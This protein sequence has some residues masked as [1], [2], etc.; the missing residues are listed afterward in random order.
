MKTIEI[1]HNRYIELET[2]NSLYSE[3]DKDGKQKLIK[4]GIKARF[5]LYLDDIQAHE[6]FLD[7]KGK[8]YKNSCRIYHR[9]IG[10][11]IINKSYEYIS[12]L[13][14]QDNSKHIGF[15]H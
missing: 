3:P 15:K 13:K 4:S 11:M 10:P 2:I 9:N 1:N 12:K 7:D 8:V 6:E 14:Q 5:S